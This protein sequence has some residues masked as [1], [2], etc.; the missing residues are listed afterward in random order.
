MITIEDL[1]YK[2]Y[3]TNNINKREREKTN[4]DTLYMKWDGERAKDKKNVI[5]LYI[6]FMTNKSWV[7]VV[8]T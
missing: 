1:E 2:V 3:V 6:L 4:W 5:W 8:A 7:L